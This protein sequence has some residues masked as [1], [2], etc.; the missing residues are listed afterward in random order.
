MPRDE[1]SDSQLET[2]D[3][4]QSAK[5]QTAP[6][7]QV[8]EESQLDDD[9]TLVPLTTHE[10]EEV[11]ENGKIKDVNAWIQ[12]QEVSGQ[13]PHDVI[14]AISCTTMNHKLADKVLDL[15]SKGKKI[16]DNIPGVWTEED[17][18]AL[19]GQD[20]RAMERV[21]EKHG[22]ELFDERW[23]FLEQSARATVFVAEEGK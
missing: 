12:K 7:F 20:G 22:S 16:P 14:A 3:E 15:L 21:M 11:K 13:N 23:Q 6:Q 18:E 9:D 19:T 5:Y 1:E 4:S 2:S 8:P 10:E 17:D